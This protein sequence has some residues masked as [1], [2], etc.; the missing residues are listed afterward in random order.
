MELTATRTLVK[1][2]PELWELLGDEL[3][4]HHWTACLCGTEGALKVIAREPGRMVAWRSGDPPA[5][6][7]VALAEKGWGTQ[8]TVFAQ[9]DGLARADLERVLDELSE[10]QRR[11][12]RAA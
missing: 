12:F 4:L 1:S 3:Q 2:P 9:G 8:V 5:T 10:P 7:K 6:V 11:P